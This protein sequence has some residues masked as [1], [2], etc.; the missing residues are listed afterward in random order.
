MLGPTPVATAT[1]FFDTTS[2]AAHGSCTAYFTA[3]EC[4]DD[5]AVMDTLLAALEQWAKQRGARELLGPMSPRMS[6]PRGLLIEGG[7]SPVF[8]MTYSAPYYPALFEALRFDKATDL[9]EFIVPCSAEYPRLNKVAE[10][11][12]RRFPS[13]RLRPFDMDR[14]DQ[15]FAV[16]A[17]IYNAA[18]RAAWGFIELSPEDLAYTA[19]GL[20]K[21]LGPACAVFVEVD[22]VPIGFQMAV[23]DLNSA[24]KAIGGSLWPFGWLR[25]KRLIARERTFRALFI[26]VLPRYRK[27]GIEAILIQAGLASGAQR[28]HIG[29]VLESNFAWKSE[30]ENLTGADLAFK[31][32]RIYRKS[33]EGNPI[34]NASAA[35]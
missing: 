29:W 20:V 24:I 34:G 21:M 2:A 22:G 23:P 9:Y 33:F 14:M 27:S 4:A 31:K 11:A 13:L 18:W 28:F 6:D 7:G 8:G 35:Q 32:Y 16:M 30:I 5:V 1:A 10:L 3:F 15:E 25:V 12:K 26:G 17:Q 19:G